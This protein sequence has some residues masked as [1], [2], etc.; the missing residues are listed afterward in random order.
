MS[1]IGLGRC[2]VDSIQCV[3][4]R[5]YVCVRKRRSG[6]RK[7]KTETQRNAEIGRRRV[8]E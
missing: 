1:K 5:V 3:R 7:I 8:K 4:V 2:L 6:Q